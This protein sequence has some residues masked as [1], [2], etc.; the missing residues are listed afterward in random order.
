MAFTTTEDNLVLGHVYGKAAYTMPAA[1]YVSLSS[2]APVKAGTGATEI[3]NRVT[4]AAANIAAASASSITTSADTTF[5]AMAAAG[6]ATY[7]C[8]WT[9]ASGGTL[10]MFIP[11]SASKAYAIGDIPFIAAGNMTTSLS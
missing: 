3:T 8:V 9:A 6:T 11:L 2:T 7:I 10:R 5:N 1:L 4:V